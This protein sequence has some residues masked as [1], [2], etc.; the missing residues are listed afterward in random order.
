MSDVE[1][2]EPMDT[3]AAPV[4]AAAAAGNMDINTAIQEVLKNSLIADGLSRGLRETT[5]ALDKRQAL[6]CILADN[7]DEAMYTKLITALCAEHSIP[8]VHVDC[9]M[10]L[11]EWAGL[12]KLDSDGKA[13]KIVRCS[14]LVI[15]SYG[16]RSAAT[17]VFE[18][19]LKSNAK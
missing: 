14:S 10:K 9:N 8:L 18:A 4:A 6:C 3:G 13:R 15:K 5:K 17:D 19:Y 16:A 11:G 7:C 2:D 12:C 1:G